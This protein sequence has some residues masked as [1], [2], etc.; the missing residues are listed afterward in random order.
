M[1][2]HHPPM[3]AAYRGISWQSHVIR[4]YTRSA[5]SHV[6]WIDTNGA[7]YEAW[8]GKVRKAASLFVHHTPGTVVDL[9]DVGGMFSDRIRQV[10]EFHAVQV[11]KP[12]DWLGILRM[13]TRRPFSTD[14]QRKWFCSELVHA[15]HA[16]AGLCL[17]VMPPWKVTPEIL[18]ASP[19]LTRVMTV[20]VGTGEAPY[21]AAWNDNP[22]NA[23]N[24]L[25][26]ASDK[27]TALSPAKSAK[28]KMQW[29]SGELHRVPAMGLQEAMFV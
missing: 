19:L 4:W 28:A 14:D 26:T 12:Y 16:A 20:T 25:A 21:W 8:K 6:A 1:S 9:F 7:C 10:R 17:Q 15:A 11:G 18:C 23:Q 3:I 5:Y 24:G 29:G 22:A 13:V 2:M 27:P